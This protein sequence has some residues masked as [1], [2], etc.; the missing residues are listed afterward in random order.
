[1]EIKFNSGALFTHKDKSIEYLGTCLPSVQEV[2]EICVSG[3][4]PLITYTNVAELSYDMKL[5]AKI[6]N[7]I[8]YD[9]PTN[10]NYISF[11][12]PITIQARWHKKSR[13]RKKWLKHYGMKR[14]TVKVRADV[15]E[16]TPHIQNYDETYRE[17]IVLSNCNSYNFCAENIEYIWRPDQK[18]RGIK[19]VW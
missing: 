18:R 3:N 7:Y 17:D 5:D 1:M 4:V 9:K 2:P 12:V 11:N 16:V 19:I 10:V 6:L 8:V 13:I 14:D 15:I